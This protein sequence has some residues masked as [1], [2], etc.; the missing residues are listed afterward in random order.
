MQA[1]APDRLP[2]PDRA[3]AVHARR[4]AEFLRERIKDAGG[5]LSFADFMHYALYAPGLGYYTAGT[6]K[7]GEAGDFV[8][9]PEVSSLFG[10]VVARQCTDV[11][12]A[13]ADATIVEV[14]AGSGKLAVDLLSRL[15]ELD[16][17]P[18]RYQILEPSADLAD[19]QARR[20]AAELPDVADHVEWLEHRPRHVN[21]VV[22]ANEVI[23]AMPV[24]RFVRRSSVMQ[25]RVAADGDGFALIEA[26]APA[27]LAEAV[28]AVEAELG[29]RLPDGYVSEICLAA[30]GWVQDVVDELD[31]GIA[32]LFDY[33]VS[34]REY[35]G[36]ERNG[37][38]LRCHFRHH[39][40]SNPLIL[41]GI[42]DI[43]SWVDFTALAGAAVDAG[44][45]IGGFVTQ[46]SFL[47]DGGLDAELAELASLPT[48]QQVALSSQ[49]KMLTLPGGMGEHFKCIAFTQGGVEA[50]AA[51]RRNDRTHTL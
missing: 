32:L 28:E 43:T 42:Q 33:G 41:T 50:P 44:A 47:I 14:G 2:D 51:F 25:Q 15:A 21:G 24:E 45:R 20:I 48:A 38:W 39:A 10:R 13:T 9:A 27:L 30:P 17:L 49:V 4:C 18:A 36:A 7:F 29:E 3:S 31:A 26:P 34:R 40:H 46:S 1:G 11:L 8:T 5:T 6:I 23:D 16:T 22:I 35:Y 12:R 19:R 37:G